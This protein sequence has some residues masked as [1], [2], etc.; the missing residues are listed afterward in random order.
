[1]TVTETFFAINVRDMERAKKFYV[2]TFGATV[3]AASER[4]TSIYIARVRIGLFH[5]PEHKGGW[6][7]LHF[8]VDDLASTLASV[9]GHGGR[10]AAPVEVAPGVVLVDVTDPEGN[11]VSLRQES[12]AS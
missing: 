9:E 10:C 3:S 12:A 8:V 5:H 2:D 7:G 1:M 6:T 4:W 11:V